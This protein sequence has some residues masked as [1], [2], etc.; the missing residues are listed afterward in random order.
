L[1][2]LGGCKK[3]QTVTNALLDK[4]VREPDNDSLAKAFHAASDSLREAQAALGQLSHAPGK[5]QDKDYF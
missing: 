1:L 3:W 5:T 2:R 4:L